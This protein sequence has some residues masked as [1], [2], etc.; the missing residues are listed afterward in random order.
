MQQE[1]LE[2]LPPSEFEALNQTVTAAYDLA[3][4]GQLAEGYTLLLESEHEARAAAERGVP[5]S[6]VLRWI[7]SVAQENYTYR[8]GLFLR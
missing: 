4:S 2:W 3:A 8:Y 1:W 7:Y 5:W 6:S